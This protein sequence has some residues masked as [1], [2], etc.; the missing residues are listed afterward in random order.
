M[1]RPGTTNS[2][3]R[4]ESARQEKKHQEIVSF[5]TYEILFMFLHIRSTS[6][7]GVVVKKSVYVSHNL[8]TTEVV[9]GYPP[10]VLSRTIPGL[11]AERVSECMY[12]H[13]VFRSFF[14][15]CPPEVRRG[16]GRVLWWLNGEPLQ[17]FD[18]LLPCA[19]Y[20][21]ATVALIIPLPELYR[22]RRSRNGR[23]FIM[24]F[25][26]CSSPSVSVFD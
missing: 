4:R 12:S 5:R 9:G 18:I 1:C 7:F 15:I 2:K 25:F 8:L 26:Y 13:P 11:R 23:K 16:C 22:R 10:C 19:Y 17:G 6:S 14:A 3:K 20:R 21:Y 24:Y